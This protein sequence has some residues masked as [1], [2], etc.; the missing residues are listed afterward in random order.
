[1]NGK[2]PMIDRPATEDAGRLA[3]GVRSDGGPT[4][5]PRGQAQPTAD[6]QQQR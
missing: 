3:I 6:N 4:V 5:R 1:M 2:I